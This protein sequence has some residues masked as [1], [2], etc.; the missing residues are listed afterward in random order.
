MENSID[1]CESSKSVYIF[2]TW[3]ADTLGLQSFPKMWKHQG[4]A[5]E[6]RIGDTQR[7]MSKC[8]RNNNNDNNNNNNSTTLAKSP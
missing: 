2:S 3:F 7:M 5:E 8:F 6:S 4:K 1:V